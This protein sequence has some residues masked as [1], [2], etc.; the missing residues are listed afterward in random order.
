MIEGAWSVMNDSE[1]GHVVI[2]LTREADDEGGAE[3]DAG[4]T[5]ANAVQ[6]RVVFDGSPAVCCV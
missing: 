2:R 1:F 4:H 3:G 5:C 6:E